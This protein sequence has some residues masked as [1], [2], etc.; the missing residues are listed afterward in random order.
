MILTTHSIV[1]AS[2]ANLFPNHPGLGFGLSFASHYLL[3]TITHKDYNI[4]GFVDKDSKTIK[5]LF[6][7]MKSAIHL[8]FV[9]ADFLVGVILCVLIFVR[10]EKTAYLT[11]LGVLGGVLPDIFQF[12]YMK[13]KKHP[14]KAFQ[15]IHDEVHNRE[16]PVTGYLSQILSILFFVSMYFL[17]K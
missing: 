2:I 6:N 15:K 16:T 11:A 7:N 17:F 4:S 5:S 1:G 3:D 9:G 8:M 14:F 10:D 12:L 13:Y